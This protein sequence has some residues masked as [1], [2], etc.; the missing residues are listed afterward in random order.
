M[1]FGHEEHLETL[2]DQFDLRCTSC[3]AQ[4]VQT[5]HISV[6]SATCNSCHFQGVELN[7]GIPECLTLCYSAIAQPEEF[8]MSFDHEAVLENNI[9]CMI[10]HIE[11]VKGEGEVD[12]E[13][14]LFCHSEPERFERIEETPFLHATHTSEN[15]VECFQCHSQIRHGWDEWPEQPQQVSQS[16]FY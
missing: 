10:C 13:K 6:S 11:P 15:K 5:E 9:D 7:E 3:H 16:A 8:E 12:Q 2:N 1:P 14:C 4:V